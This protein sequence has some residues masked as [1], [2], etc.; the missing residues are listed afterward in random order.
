[1]VGESN[2]NVFLIQI[3]RLEFCR[4]R[5]IRVR[6]IE[7]RLYYPIIQQHTACLVLHSFTVGNQAFLFSCMPTGKPVNMLRWHTNTEVSS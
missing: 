4:I 3:G 5:D 6:N 1:M 7:S 2:E